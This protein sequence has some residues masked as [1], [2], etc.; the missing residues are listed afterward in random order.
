MSVTASGFADFDLQAARMRPRPLLG[1]GSPLRVRPGLSDSPQ[2]GGL[3]S[4]ATDNQPAQRAVA[5][6]TIVLACI[7]G[8]TSLALRFFMPLT[9]SCGSEWT[10][11]RRMHARYVRL[12]LPLCGLLTAA[13]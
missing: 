13:T 1:P 11:L 2:S 12:F 10:K 6:G 8:C 4:C 9:T 3:L 7:G 5:F